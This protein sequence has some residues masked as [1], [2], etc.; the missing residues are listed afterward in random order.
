MY[1]ED[2]SSG[3]YFIECYI[4][5]GWEIPQINDHDY[6]KFQHQIHDPG[7]IEQGIYF[8]IDGIFFMVEPSR[9]VPTQ[10]LKIPEGVLEYT[11]VKNPPT[12]RGIKIP[13]PWMFKYLRTHD[14]PRSEAL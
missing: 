4:E 6:R 9:H 11:K 3:Y 13:K 2:F 1:V 5:P 10:V 14:I 12:R 8:Q 7:S